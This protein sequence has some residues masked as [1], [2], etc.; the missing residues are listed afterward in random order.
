LV[1]YLTVSTSEIFVR[2]RLV[3]EE[4]DQAVCLKRNIDARSCNH[5][6]RGKAKN[7]T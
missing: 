3:Y 6:C 5:C 7:V 4:Q 2:V 1:K